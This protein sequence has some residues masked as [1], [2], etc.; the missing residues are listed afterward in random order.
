[1]WELRHRI[2]GER[3]RYISAAVSDLSK[4]F[5]RLPNRLMS[6]NAPNLQELAISG[7]QRIRKLL[8]CYPEHVLEKAE[9]EAEPFDFLLQYRQ[10]QLLSEVR[11]MLL[12]H[13]WSQEV[14]DRA[15][16][17]E[18]PLAVFREELISSLPPEIRDMARQKEDENLGQFVI[19]YVDLVKAA[20]SQSKAREILFKKSVI[21]PPDFSQVF[22]ASPTDGVV[23]MMGA[24]DS[25]IFENLKFPEGRDLSDP[26][27]RS[28]VENACLRNDYTFFKKLGR[29][30]TEPPTKT[31]GVNPDKLSFFLV[32]RWMPVPRESGVDPGLCWFT[33]EAITDRNSRC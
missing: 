19:Q 15:E 6:R 31:A 24:A 1:M 25:F 27:F 9:K 10:R 18:N 12:N 32:N 30:L 29:A 3:V 7:G 23:R 21:F 16:M 5:G 33:D 8:S 22:E 4:R 2:R 13:G 17:S 11:P 20:E 28:R 26:W 14:I